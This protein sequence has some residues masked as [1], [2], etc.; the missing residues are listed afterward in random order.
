MYPMLS[1]GRLPNGH[2]ACDMDDDRGVADHP[3]RLESG[4]PKDPVSPPIL[5]CFRLYFGYFRPHK[6][7]SQNIFPVKL[8]PTF[9]NSPPQPWSLDSAD[10][11]TYY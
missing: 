6:E 2:G 9:H 4:L 3:T 8:L 1:M 7:T 5:H 10:N 11:M